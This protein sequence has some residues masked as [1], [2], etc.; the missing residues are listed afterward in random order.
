MSCFRIMNDNF[1]DA[2][3]FANTQVSSEQS[4]FQ[5]SNTHAKKRR[6]RI[7]RSGGFFDVTSSN[8]TIIFE[9]TA[10][11]NLTAT[12]TVAEYS[13]VSAFLTAVKSAFESTGGSTYTVTQDSTT[14]KIKIESDGAGGGGIFN[15]EMANAS[16]TAEDLLGFSST[17]LTGSLSYTA[18][19]IR[20]NSEE[21]LTF[22]F[23]L[24]TNPENFI[25]TGR[26]NNAIQLSSSGTYKLLGNETD[27][28]GSPTFT[29]TLTYDAEVISKLGTA[30]SGLHTGPLRYW[31]VE[32][33]D[34][35]NPNGFLELSNIFLGNAFGDS[36]TGRVQFPFA[37]QFLDQSTTQVSFGGS[38]FSNLREKT[39]RFSARWFN[40]KKAEVEELEAIY[41]EFGTSTPFFIS[42]DTDAVFS[43]SANRR[44]SYVKLT[45][46]PTWSLD[47]PDIF[48]ATMQFNEEI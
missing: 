16:T 45:G 32:F 36:T 38:T 21:T 19:F 35:D 37:S 31:R 48:S 29:T 4:S 42:M 30:G 11:S 23:G 2:Q 5:A 18:D 20:I 24:P 1:I 6:A 28:W 33:S 7:W 14:L 15:L 46:P 8:N 27:T 9:E 26:R 10:A 39:Q 25:M 3:I 41:D 44:I 40:L 22:D 47:N 43:T 12:I 13:S 34:I 17:D